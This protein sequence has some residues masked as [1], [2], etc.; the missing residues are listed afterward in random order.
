M[1][2]CSALVGICTTASDGGFMR[3]MPL[4]AVLNLL[5][6]LAGGWR[7]ALFNST[8]PDVYVV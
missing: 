6:L 3:L 8:D 7:P 2:A 5:A 1:F 4:A